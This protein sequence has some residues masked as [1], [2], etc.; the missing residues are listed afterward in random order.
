MDPIAVSM[1]V[2]CYALFLPFFCGSRRGFCL[3]FYKQG[4]ML[5][6]K[7]K[8]T[9][10]GQQL[11][12]GR[13]LTTGVTATNMCFNGFHYK[14]PPELDVYSYDQSQWP[15]QSNVFSK[16]YHTTKWPV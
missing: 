3:L 8:F 2:F 1:F 10:P 16:L 11:C 4:C 13:W 7:K 6:T 12:I 5:L 9:A 15:V 14:V